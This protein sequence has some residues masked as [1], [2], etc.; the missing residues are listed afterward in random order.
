M[1]IIYGILKDLLEAILWMIWFPV[2]MIIDLLLSFALCIW[3]IIEWVFFLCWDGV[4]WI[5]EWLSSEYK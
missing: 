2:Y 4:V 1:K 3:M 5:W